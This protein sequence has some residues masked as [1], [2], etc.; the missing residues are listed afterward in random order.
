MAR[1]PYEKRTTSVLC[2]M[3]LVQGCLNKKELKNVKEFARVNFSKI[4]Y[5]DD[6]IFE[7]AKLL[8]EHHALPDGLR[9]ID[10]LIAA[11]AISRKTALATSN[12]AHFKAIDGLRIERFKP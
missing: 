3:E 9:T 8:L 12:Y 5:P 11:S 2:I 7:K 4:I 1:V 10:A 6:R